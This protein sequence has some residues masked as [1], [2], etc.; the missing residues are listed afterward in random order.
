MNNRR[1]TIGESSKG[2]SSIIDN[3]T[4]D[5]D[6]WRESY[7]L[8]HICDMLE[9]NPEVADKHIGERC[10]E[11]EGTVANHSYGEVCFES[12][13]G[14]VMSIERHV[15]LD[16]IVTRTNTMPWSAR[17]DHINARC[18]LIHEIKPN[19]NDSEVKR[20][21]V[22]KSENFKLGDSRI[23]K[24]QRVFE[25]IRNFQAGNFRIQKFQAEKSENFKIRKFQAEKSENFKRDSKK[26]EN[27]RLGNFKMEKSE[28]FKPK[29]LGF[30]NFTILVKNPRISMKSSKKLENFKTRYK[31]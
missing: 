13:V 9:S 5:S 29:I 11:N 28:N 4:K 26:S 30:K 15:S 14:L 23:Q 12:D 16:S 1:F 2:K 10:D 8:M 3:V 18:I 17:D 25:K 19:S 7:N 27:F 20:I 21:R 24:I 22:R 6:G 31:N